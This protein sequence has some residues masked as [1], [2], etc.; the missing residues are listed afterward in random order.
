MR[1]T[2]KKIVRSRAPLRLGFA[3]GGTDVAPY[4][5]Q[6]GG[7]VLNA[8][9]DL[10]ANCTLEYDPNGT[11]IKL[12][13]LDLGVSEILPLQS[14][15]PLNGELRLHRAIYNCV[16]RDYLGGK[17]IAVNV[18]TW[19]DAPPGSGLGTSSTL[20]V[21]ILAAYAELLSLPLGEYDIANLAYKIERLDCRLAGGKQDQY[22][23]TFGGFNFMEFYEGERVIVNPLRIRRHIELELESSLLLYFTG[24]SRESAQIIDDQVKA[25]SID[26][27]PNTKVINAMHQVKQM[28]YAMKESI[29]KG[30]INGFHTN[31]GA[32]WAAK[33]QMA[34]SI[35]NSDIEVIASRVLDAGAKAVKISGAG[36]GGF[37][38]ISIDPICRYQ[39]M[40]ALKEIGGVFHEFSFVNHGVET[41]KVC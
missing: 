14:L 35:S 27:E 23:A 25:A 26:G 38:M 3:G 2:M 34:H 32:S 30:D 8:T 10:F 41:W 18:S 36:G 4:C 1:E 39:I 21:S 29:L 9:I 22:A 40:A 17:P 33:K 13:A 37:M 11:F 12:Q 28:A 6:Y 31:L 24:R 15:L 19:S 7:C 20:V 16:V 5:D